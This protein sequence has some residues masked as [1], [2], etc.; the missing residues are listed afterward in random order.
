MFP[1]ICT[2]QLHSINLIQVHVGMGALIYLYLGV[3]LLHFENSKLELDSSSHT[4]EMGSDI[5][6]HALLPLTAFDLVF[7]QTTFVTGWFVEGTI[8]EKALSDALGR[9]TQKWRMLAGRLHSIKSP[10]VSIFFPPVF[11]S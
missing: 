4:S 10:T 8:D 5:E 2:D 11:C 1:Q 7:Q 3:E 9:L 6:Q